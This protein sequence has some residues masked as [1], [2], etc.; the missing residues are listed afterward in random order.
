ML[1][2]CIEED[3]SLV[4]KLLPSVKTKTGVRPK[5]SEK[6]RLYGDFKLEFSE[7]KDPR[8]RMASEKPTLS[9]DDAIATSLN[10]IREQ[11]FLE[12]VGMD[13]DA[14]VALMLFEGER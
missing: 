2:G 13:L 7:G 8:K 12:V 14:Q 6:R 1:G 9:V 3:I 5:Q 10:V 4:T 11:P